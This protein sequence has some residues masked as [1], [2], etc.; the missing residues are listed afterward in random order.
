MKIPEDAIF[1]EWSL[2]MFED[3]V[4][5]SGASVP[6]NVQK[7]PRLCTKVGGL[8]PIDPVFRN[9]QVGIFR[10]TWPLG[11][12][13]RG[14]RLKSILSPA[15]GRLP[16]HQPIRD[17]GERP[18][19]ERSCGH[20]DSPLWGFSKGVGKRGPGSNTQVLATF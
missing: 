2:R 9:D 11:G 6:E 17:D 10:K 12:D 3:A 5:C 4:T 1:V 15:K 13:Y 19:G 8:T 7:P 14:D 20:G 18:R 16:T